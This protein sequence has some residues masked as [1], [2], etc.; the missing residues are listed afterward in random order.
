MR[1]ARVGQQVEQELVAGQGAVDS[2][3]RDELGGL[4]GQG[5]SWGVG[6]GRADWESSQPVSPRRPTE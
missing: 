3:L 1:V 5:E 4:V 6:A 2:W